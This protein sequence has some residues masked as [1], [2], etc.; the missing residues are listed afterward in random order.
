[1]FVNSVMS[2]KIRS[3]LYMMISAVCCMVC[4]FSTDVCDNSNIYL[5]V[6]IISNNVCNNEGVVF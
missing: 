5:I 3:V 1:M 4:S 6:S 2:I